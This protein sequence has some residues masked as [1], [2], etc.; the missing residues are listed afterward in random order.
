MNPAQPNERPGLTQRRPNPLEGLVHT[1]TVVKPNSSRPC[2][3]DVRTIAQVWNLREFQQRLFAMISPGWECRRFLMGARWR[4]GSAAGE[5]W[6]G[7]RISRL[8]RS[9]VFGQLVFGG[10]G[11]CYLSWV[12]QRPTMVELW[13]R[14]WCAVGYPF[15]RWP[16]RH[17]SDLPVNPAPFA[18]LAVG[19]PQRVMKFPPNEA[20]VKITFIGSV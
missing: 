18:Q 19:C 2:P 15:S 5:L 6:N 16:P 10:L 4:V 11:N 17:Y 3:T 9:R 7:L 12:A 13:P 1:A 20:N 8:A 14:A